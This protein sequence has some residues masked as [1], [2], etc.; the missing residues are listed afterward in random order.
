MKLSNHFSISG[1]GRPGPD[2]PARVPRRE[3]LR[4][5]VR[6]AALAALA[7]LAGRV[8]GRRS[9]ATCAHPPGC[10]TCPVFGDC[11]LPQAQANKLLNR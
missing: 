2:V 8:L 7:L 5:S 9:I 1:P 3:F 11:S 4:G 10:A 6:Y